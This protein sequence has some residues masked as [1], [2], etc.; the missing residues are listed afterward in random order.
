VFHRPDA[1]NSVTPGRNRVRFSDKAGVASVVQCVVVDRAG[2]HV[3]ALRGFL[4]RKPGFDSPCAT[5]AWRLSWLLSPFV[6]PRQ[7]KGAFHACTLPWIV[8]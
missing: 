4:V 1:E 7:E 2:G 5:L 6:P 3:E 8:R